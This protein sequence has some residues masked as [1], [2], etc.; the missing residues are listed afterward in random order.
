MSLRTR[1]EYD[2]GEITIEELAVSNIDVFVKS[3]QMRIASIRLYDVDGRDFYY[4][5]HI[6]FDPW[7]EATTVDNIYLLRDFKNSLENYICAN[8]IGVEDIDSIDSD[9]IFFTVKKTLLE[10]N[11]YTD[12]IV[13]LLTKCNRLSEEDEPSDMCMHHHHGSFIH[14]YKWML[15]KKKEIAEKDDDLEVC[16]IE[17]E[18]VLPFEYPAY[19]YA[20][21]MNKNFCQ[22]QEYYKGGEE[23]AFEESYTYHW[24]VS[25]KND[26]RKMFEE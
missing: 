1:E 17:N 22:W 24:D 10:E 11:G 13:E 6:K 18:D 9:G 2:N 14:L 21:M 4:N 23:D 15:D 5:F 7:A 25:E 3:H 20:S 26:L 19:F 12:E 8:F 16:D